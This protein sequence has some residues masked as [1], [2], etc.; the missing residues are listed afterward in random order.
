MEK[1]NRRYFVCCYKET[2]TEPFRQFGP[3]L[4]AN[5]A[6]GFADHLT[7]QAK[8]NKWDWSDVRVKKMKG[9]QS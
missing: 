1:I 7:A 3:Y 4:T 9:S 5:D 2:D 6:Q 8:Q